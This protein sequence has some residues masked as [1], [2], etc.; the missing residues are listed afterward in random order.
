MLDLF[1]DGAAM[2][3]AKI[4]FE[5]TDGGRAAE[6]VDARSRRPAHSPRRARVSAATPSRSRI[7][8]VV[9]ENDRQQRATIRAFPPFK[10]AHRGVRGHAR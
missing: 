7:G 1:G 10:R 6:V 2:T 9:M 4:A 8:H 3:L 5:W